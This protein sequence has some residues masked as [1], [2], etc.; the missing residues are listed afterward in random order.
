MVGWQGSVFLWFLL[1]NGTSV[2]GPNTTEH[3]PPRHSHTCTSEP[4][5]SNLGA[6]TFCPPSHQPRFQTASRL[7]AE[8]GLCG[9][10]LDPGRADR[11]EAPLSTRRGPEAVCEGIILDSSL[12]KRKKN[13]WRIH[14][15][16]CSKRHLR[17]TDDHPINARLTTN[18]EPSGGGGGGGLGFPRPSNK[19]FHCTELYP[20]LYRVHKKLL[21]TFLFFFE[22]EEVEAIKKTKLQFLNFF[23]FLFR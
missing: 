22:E 14:F 15:I 20:N 2:A 12:Q 4:S 7:Q 5:S 6:S 9:P 1:P 17:S 16:C 18:V 3:P 11:A 19:P 8:H 10:G 23:F 21:E 13:F